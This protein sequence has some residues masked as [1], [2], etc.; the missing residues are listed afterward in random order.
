MVGFGFAL[1]FN[2]TQ[3]FNFAQGEFLMLGAMMHYTGTVIFKLPFA[4]S[5][6]L[7]LGTLSMVA[8]FIELVAISPLRKKSANVIMMV[9]A[10]IAFSMLFKN[11]SEMIW[12]KYPLM[13]K[14]FFVQEHFQIAGIM[15]QSQSLAVMI[16]TAISLVILWL[17]F[18]K[19][20]FGMAVMASAYNTK[21]AYLCGVS[22]HTMIIASFVLSAATSALAGT[23]VGPIAFISPSMGFELGIKGFAAA[24][25]GG[26]G[27]PVGAILGGLLIGVL[28]SL[29]GCYVSTAYSTLMAFTFML[30]V[31]YI[32]PEGILGV[33]SR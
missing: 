4:L 15:V 22:V 26:M 2:S 10:F 32:R 8:I 14:G 18:S 27:S 12:G 17:F 19:T 31:L 7:S 24:V 16:T 9:L 5:L 28:E 1:V 21:R 11:V 33:A 6:I 13:V 3:I 20:M 25:V 29:L 30:L 23:I